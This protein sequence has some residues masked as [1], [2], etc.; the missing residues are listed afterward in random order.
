MGTQFLVRWGPNGDL[1]QQE[2]GPKSVFL[3]IDRNKL[4]SW[5]TEEKNNEK[6]LHRFNFTDKLAW[7]SF[8]LVLS[9]QVFKW[10]TFNRQWLLWLLARSSAWNRENGDLVKKMGTWEQ[11]YWSHH[12]LSMPVFQCWHMPVFEEVL[13]N[14]RNWS[15]TFKCISTVSNCPLFGLVWCDLPRYVSS[16][17]LMTKKVP[18]GKRT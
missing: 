8:K 18:S 14:T 2:W 9:S 6:N 4:I 13:S 11:W 12:R 10:S 15:L 17:S 3:E 16:S 1:C 7:C 5:N